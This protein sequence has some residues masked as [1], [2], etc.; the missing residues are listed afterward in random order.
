[1]DTAI[2]VLRWIAVL[3][4]AFL[5]GGLARIVLGALNW[6]TVPAYDADSILGQFGI[7]CIMGGA[8][9]AAFVWTGAWIAPSRKNGTGLALAALVVVASSFSVG[10]VV[11]GAATSVSLT[12]PASLG[13]LIA[14]PAT[15]IYVFVLA[16][17]GELD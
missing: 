1:M 8:F 13:E 11:I 4:G 3:P 6:L 9:A 17:R 5:A 16:W 10:L 15:A 12:D 14:A 2:S 7:G